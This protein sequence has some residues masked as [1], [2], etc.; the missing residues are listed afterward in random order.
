MGWLG[1][2]IM[3]DVELKPPTKSSGDLLHAIAKAGLSL[4]PGVGAA[5][6]LLME[7]FG[8]PVERRRLEW[9]KTVAAVLDDL[10]Q[11]RGVTV[12][13]LQNN[14]TFIDAVIQASQAAARTSQGEKRAALRAA[15]L[16]AGLPSAPDDSLQQMFIHYVD[17]FTVWH[18]KLLQL[19]RNPSAW[20]TSAGRKAPEFSMAGSLDAVLLEAYPELRGR[21]EFYD[22]IW[23]DLYQRR[24]LNTEGL[25]AMMTGQGTMGK[26]TT[27]LGDQFLAFITDPK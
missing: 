5:G 27:E 9:A 26:R 12:E 4:I 23:H 25:H 14:E 7:V 2:Q 17:V 18:L 10:Q 13:Q 21:R 6:T 20:F 11:N 3:A 8:P 19:F 1:E 24:L 16:N 22:S 15:I